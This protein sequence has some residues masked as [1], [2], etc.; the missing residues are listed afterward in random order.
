MITIVWF[1]GFVKAFSSLK[2]WRLDKLWSC[3]FGDLVN[4]ERR[5]LCRPCSI[6]LVLNFGEDRWV[7]EHK[8]SQKQQM[9]HGIYTEPQNKFT[10]KLWVPKQKQKTSW[11]RR[12]C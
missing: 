10:M 3:M 11:R 4:I 2:A 1:G 8:T 6:T 7:I 5:F 9:T 12:L